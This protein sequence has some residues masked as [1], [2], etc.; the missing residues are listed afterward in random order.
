MSQAG[1][2]L[3]SRHAR[4]LG[5]AKSYTANLSEDI[6]Q[7]HDEGIVSIGGLMW[8][9]VLGHMPREITDAVNASLEQR[10]MPSLATQR[11]V[12]GV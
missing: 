11:A 2:N 1:W 8:Q 4:V 12:P 5:F 7:I 9:F 3:G 6:K 10:D